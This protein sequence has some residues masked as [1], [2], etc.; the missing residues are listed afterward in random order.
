MSFLTSPW[1][2]TKFKWTP[3]LRGVAVK[4]PTLSL[5][6]SI[7]RPAGPQFHCTYMLPESEDSESE[8]DLL[9]SRFTPTWNVFWCIGAYSKH[10]NIQ[11]QI[12]TTHKKSTT[13]KNQK[14]QYIRYKYITMNIKKVRSLPYCNQGRS[15]SYCNQVSHST[16]SSCHSFI[17][18]LHTRLR[19][20][21]T[22]SVGY[23]LLWGES[24]WCTHK[25][26]MAYGIGTSHPFWPVSCYY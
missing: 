12:S 10:K 14:T 2:C 22:C 4:K 11:T 3:K 8:L 5:L 19:V 18:D 24:S 17:G 21:V 6:F 13:H 23:S 26:T 16:V 15:L 25:I 7:N 1:C 20:D 9:S